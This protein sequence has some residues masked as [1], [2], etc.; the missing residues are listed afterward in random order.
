MRCCIGTIQDIKRDEAGIRFHILERKTVVNLRVVEC[1]TAPKVTG[2]IPAPG[3]LVEADAQDALAGLGLS[4]TH[5]QVLER[6]IRV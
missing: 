5:L 1:V 3:S 2:E 6:A 4:V